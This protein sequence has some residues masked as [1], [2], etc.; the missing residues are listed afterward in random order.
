GVIDMRYENPLMLAE[1]AA[2]VDLISA[3]RLALGVSR[4]SPETVLRG[5]EAFGYT[6]SEDERGADIAR[7][8][9]DLFLRAIDGE[10]LA[11]RDPMSP[12]GGG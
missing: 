7:E 8:H 4:G 5:Y 12:F 6:G 10:G 3:N 11:E 2:S 1:E 9:F